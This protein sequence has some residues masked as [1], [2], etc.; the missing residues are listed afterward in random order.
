MGWVAAI[1]VPYASGRAGGPRCAIWV[2]ST[3]GF[4]AVQR[5]AGSSDVEE[6]GGEL[7]GSAVTMA[8][9]PPGKFVRAVIMKEA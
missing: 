4:R 9:C 6:Y 8:S 3:A 7:G 1:V 2:P 5:P